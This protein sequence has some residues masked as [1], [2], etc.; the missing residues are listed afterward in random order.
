MEHFE[1]YFYVG[2]FTWNEE[3]CLEYVL[4]C[5]ESKWICCGVMY[6]LWNDVR[7]YFSIWAETFGNDHMI[8]NRFIS[9]FCFFLNNVQ[10][11]FRGVSSFN[12]DVSSWNTSKVTDMYV[13]SHG[14]RNMFGVCFCVWWVEM[15]LMWSHVWTLE[16]CQVVLFNLC[17]DI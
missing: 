3:L 14:M 10:Y 9:L 16:W 13:S 2:K 12:N 6:E 5:D 15:N 1:G 4:V 11:M 7:L 8:S 17:C